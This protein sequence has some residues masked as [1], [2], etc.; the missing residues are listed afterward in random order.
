MIYKLSCVLPT[1]HMGY[2]ASKPKESVVYCLIKPLE[3]HTLHNSTYPYSPYNIYARPPLGRIIARKRFMLTMLTKYL[4]HLNYWLYV[5][6]RLFNIIMYCSNSSP[7]QD[8]KFKFPSAYKPLPVKFP[9]NM[10]LI[11]G[12][13]PYVCWGNLK[14]R[15]DRCMNFI[16]KQVKNYA[17]NRVSTKN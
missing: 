10:A 7:Y 14:F 3:N 2:H 5:V 16:R 8:K 12:Q 1:S 11:P 17:L 6:Q 13:I 15:I 4:S 9:T